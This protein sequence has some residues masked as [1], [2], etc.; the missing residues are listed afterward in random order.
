MLFKIN[1]AHEFYVSLQ[2]DLSDSMCFLYL[3]NFVKNYMMR[4]VKVY[5]SRIL[6][7]GQDIQIS[8][9]W[10]SWQDPYLNV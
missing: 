3:C 10:P 9:Y 2:Q 1:S 8:K 4:W 5:K 6:G 7:N